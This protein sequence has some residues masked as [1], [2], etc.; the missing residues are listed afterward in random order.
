MSSG[1]RRTARRVPSRR[2]LLRRRTRAVRRSASPS[3]PGSIRRSAT[4][5]GWIRIA[6]RQRPRSLLRVR[7]VRRRPCNVY[8]ALAGARPL[9]L[10]TRGR[11]LD[12]M[13]ALLSNTSIMQ[14][15]LRRDRLE[16]HEVSRGPPPRA[17]GSQRAR[18]A[19]AVRPAALSGCWRRVTLLNRPTGEKLGSV[20]KV[21]VNPNGVMSAEGAT[22]PI[23]PAAPRERNGT[24]SGRVGSASTVG[25]LAHYIVQP[26]G[27]GTSVARTAALGGGEEFRSSVDSGRSQRCRSSQFGS[28]NR[29]T[30]AA[31][32]WAARP[33]AAERPML[34]LGVL[35]DHRHA[36]TT[37]A[38]RGFRGR[39]IPAPLHDGRGAEL[40]CRDSPS[41]QWRPL[42]L[43]YPR[44]WPL[45]VREGSFTA[46][47]CTLTAR[48]RSGRAAPERSTTAPR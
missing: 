6:E 14:V 28:Y 11:R 22:I 15:P 36:A 39:D 18:C 7:R 4:N 16:V 5:S 35:C 30:Y 23:R 42:P 25:G 32:R 34:S 44:E 10:P 24:D 33:A 27:L 46:R 17:A 13:L 48:R 9:A 3:R 2:L 40:E 38:V 47:P 31:K 45:C 20:G 19:A 21:R 37:S 12:V 26:K 43:T 41:G 1:L 29:E 8:D